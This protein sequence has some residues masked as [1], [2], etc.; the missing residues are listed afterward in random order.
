MAGAGTAQWS[1][2]RINRQL[3]ANK[4]PCLILFGEHD[5]V[6]PPGNAQLMAAKIPQAQIKILPNTGHIFPI[7]DPQATINALIQF[8]QD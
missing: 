2:G 4:V 8:L 6:V 3:A 1:G 7:E 5:R